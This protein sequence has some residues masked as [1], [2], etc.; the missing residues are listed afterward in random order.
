[1]LRQWLIFLVVAFAIGFIVFGLG[2]GYLL[3]MFGLEGSVARMICG[4][5]AGLCIAIL[6]MRMFKRA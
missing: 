2:G 5:L 1:M 6:Y 3:P 4:G